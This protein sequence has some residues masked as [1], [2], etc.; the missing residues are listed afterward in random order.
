MIHDNLKI[1]FKA[2]CFIK[3]LIPEVQNWFLFEEGHLFGNPSHISARWCQA[4]KIEYIYWTWE[5]DHIEHQKVSTMK[6]QGERKSSTCLWFGAAEKERPG[7]PKIIIIW[8]PT[9]IF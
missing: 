9:I 7:A 6:N 1:N 4:A 2:D 5:F 3:Y 8:V